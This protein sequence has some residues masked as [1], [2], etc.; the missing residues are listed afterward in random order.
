MR[1]ATADG[2]YLIEN[3]EVTAAVNNFRFNESPL[4]LLR[5]S[6]RPGPE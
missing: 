5:E 6:D 2:V 1:S 3:G 4:D